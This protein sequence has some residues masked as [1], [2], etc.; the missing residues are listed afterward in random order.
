[1]NNI[2]KMRAIKRSVNKL[3]LI[4]VILL[5]I[6]ISVSA[7][8]VETDLQTRTSIEFAFEP[9]KK[10]KLNIIPELRFD[11]DFSLD[12]YLFEGEVG[13][14]PYKFLSLG[15]SYRFV[16]NLRQTKDTEYLNRYAFSAT[17]K[18]KFMGF[19][20]SLRLRYSNYAD[21]EVS[22][23]EFLRYKA[24]VKYDIPKGKLT[25]FIGVEAFQ[26]MSNGQLY[27][28]RYSAGVD[29]KLFKK[30]YLGIGYSF[31]YYLKE[32]KNRHIINVGY[33]IKF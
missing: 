11:Q 18:K 23:E 20:P 5:V 33:K 2:M 16:G 31:N 17:L 9:V 30:N 6:G 1:M 7:Q 15:A 32:Y 28:M 19:E 10:I 13:Y 12:R 25:P 21:E 29:Y 27:K 22:N 14:K 8:E 3:S 4:Q 26:E 24:S